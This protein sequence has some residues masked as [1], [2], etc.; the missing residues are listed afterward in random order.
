MTNITKMLYNYTRNDKKI[1]ARETIVPEHST[2]TGT[3]KGFFAEAIKMDGIFIR[4]FAGE[5][6]AN[7]H[8]LWRA[9]GF[10]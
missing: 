6:P 10:L 3:A 9:I 4:W 8:E 7:C 5:Y 2:E 1:E